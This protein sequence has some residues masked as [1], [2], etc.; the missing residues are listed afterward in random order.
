M[1]LE[2]AVCPVKRATGSRVAWADGVF[3]VAG[4]ARGRRRRSKIVPIF[5]YQCA[6]CGHVTSFLEKAGARK[7]H[8]C[9]KC[10]SED[11]EKVFSTFAT[12]SDSSSS[13]SSCPTG[14]CPL[15]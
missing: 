5:E 4:R 13:A 14:T 6:Q 1:Q 3:D 2:H 11:T 7:A 12:K 10:G 8:A 9:E 15:S